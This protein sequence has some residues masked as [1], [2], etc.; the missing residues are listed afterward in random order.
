MLRTILIDDE[1]KSLQVIAAVIEMVDQKIEIVGRYTD[2]MEGL[3][4]IKKA[5][6][7]DLLIVDI[8]MPKLTGIELIKS[9]PSIDFEI[10]FITAYRQYAINAIKLSALDYILKPFEPLE[11]KS[12]LVQAK[13]K[14]EV[15][16]IN[17]RVQILEDLIIPNVEKLADQKK[18]IALATLEGINY[19]W[20]EQILY[21]KGAKNYCVFYLRDGQKKIV[22]KNLGFFE[23]SLEPYNFLRVHRSHIIN[24]LLV[25]DYIKKGGGHVLMTNGQKLDVSPSN[26][27]KLLNRLEQS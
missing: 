26:K 1:P 20:M 25:T 10:I 24:I 7:L 17:E 12:A 5:K 6:A 2:P 13:H 4:A 15:K 9:V 14:R 18:R 8:E 11:L 22:S 23:D 27:E 16:K 3:S 19:V 21:I